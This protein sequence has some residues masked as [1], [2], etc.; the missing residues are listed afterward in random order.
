MTFRVLRYYLGQLLVSSAVD[1]PLTHTRA[2]T[3]TPARPGTLTVS[4]HTSGHCGDPSWL[5]ALVNIP[6]MAIQGVLSWKPFAGILAFLVWTK[7]WSGLAM[8]LMMTIEVLGIQEGARAYCA[9][10]GASPDRNG[11]AAGRRSI[12]QHVL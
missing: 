2:L 11:A 4:A 3:Y 8:S 9:S 12:E 5:L 6:D 1:C 7:E 10:F